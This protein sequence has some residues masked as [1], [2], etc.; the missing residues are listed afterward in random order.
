[1]A[2]EALPEET[3]RNR[4]ASPKEHRASPRPYQGNGQY[5][6]HELLGIKNFIDVA[7]GSGIMSLYK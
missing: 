3:G 6:K 7:I 4:Q 2:S 1:M 5:C